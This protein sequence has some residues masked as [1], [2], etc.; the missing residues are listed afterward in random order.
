MTNF[1]IRFCAK[2]SGQCWKS[3]DENVERDE[4]DV[5]SEKSGPVYFFLFIAFT[6]HFLIHYELQVG[7][8]VEKLLKQVFALSECCHS[9]PIPAVIISRS[10]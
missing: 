5:K 10:W 7:T 8:C 1:C 4:R 2:T 6:F 9:K 3:S